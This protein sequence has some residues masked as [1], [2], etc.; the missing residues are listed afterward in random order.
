[1]TKHCRK[2]SHSLTKDCK[3]R[4]SKPLILAIQIQEAL[5]RILI[6]QPEIL[7]KLI[8][9]LAR[10]ASC[11]NRGQRKCSGIGGQ[12]LPTRIN[13]NHRKLICISRTIY[14][15]SV[16][17][18]PLIDT[19]HYSLTSWAN[20]A[21]RS[22]AITG[23][24]NW[25]VCLQAFPSFPSPLFHFL[26]LVSFLAWPKPRILF[27]GLS[28]FQNQMETLAT[29]ARITMMLH[30]LSEPFYMYLK[31]VLCTIKVPKVRL[32]VFLYWHVIVSDHIS[33]Y[34]SAHAFSLFN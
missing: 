18:K 12:I 25:G 16:W 23:F 3:D 33:P 27:L 20:Q 14:D 34:Q 17:N 19:C 13:N 9:L 6:K 11:L 5:W 31:L 1:M 15:L 26:A 2:P 21:L 8:I 22:M 24:Q 28:L 32:K 10:K 30:W 29:Q 7:I 4:K